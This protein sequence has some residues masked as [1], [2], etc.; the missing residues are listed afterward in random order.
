[1]SKN[2]TFPNAEGV[3]DTYFKLVVAYLITHAVRLLVSEKNQ[4]DMLTQLETWNTIY[5]LSKNVDTRT[6]TI[7]KSKDKVKEELQTTLRSVYRDIPES[8]LTI[9]DRNTLNLPERSTTYTNAPVPSSK[10]VAK[11]ST[12][13]R[14]QHTVS[15]TDFDGSLAKPAGVR[16]CQIWMKIGSPVAHI[17][18]LSYLATDTRSPYTCLF[19]VAD[20]GKAVYYWLRWE[21]TRGETG[22]W[23]D[24]V[25]ATITG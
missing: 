23:S 2:S 14:L 8:A 22:P 16:G 3:L 7:T 17:S 24:A 18:E 12:D 1:M 15:F 6:T 21:N 13:Q 9:G 19:D 25:M 5:P 4:A 11:V 10:P 20:A